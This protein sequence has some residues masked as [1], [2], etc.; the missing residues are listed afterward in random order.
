MLRDSTIRPTSLRG[1]VESHGRSATANIVTYGL[2]LDHASDRSA[3]Q[4]Q[5][6]LDIHVIGREDQFKEQDLLEIDKIGIPLLHNIGHD[7]T[8][9]R[10]LNFRHGF[11]VV[12]LAELDD[13][14]QDLRL[15]VGQRKLG[16]G[17]LAIL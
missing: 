4:I 1:R 6:G 7:L 5:Q 16:D 11:L 2:P 15:D 3:G 17:V 10:F 13:L 12:V 9:E 8:L 14:A